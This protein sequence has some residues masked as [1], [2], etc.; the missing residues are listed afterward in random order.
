MSDRQWRD[1]VEVL[2]VSGAGLDDAYLNQWAARLG[3]G[4]LLVR[5]RADVGT[6]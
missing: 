5:A 2:R 6:P 4:A 1:V 3:I